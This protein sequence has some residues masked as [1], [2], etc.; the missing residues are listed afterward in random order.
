MT[1][2]KYER[3]SVNSKRLIALGGAVA[4]FS[5]GAYF[6]NRES[7]EPTGKI[8]RTIFEQNIVGD[9][10]PERFYTVNSDTAYVEI[11]GIPISDYFTQ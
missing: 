6:T 3:G 9:S 8:E 5:L 1:E 4:I 10:L 2:N 7:Q 11:D